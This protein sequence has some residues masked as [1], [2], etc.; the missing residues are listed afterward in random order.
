MSDPFATTG[1]RNGIGALI[2]VL[3]LVG[4]TSRAFGQG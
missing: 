1:D 4:Q 2:V 3:A